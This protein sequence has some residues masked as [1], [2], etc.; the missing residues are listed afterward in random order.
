MVIDMK[1]IQLLLN[2]GD[3]FIF[4][5]HKRLIDDYYTS[6]RLFSNLITNLDK[7][8][9]SLTDIERVIEQFNDDKVKI[10]SLFWGL[11]IKDKNNYKP[12]NLSKD[13]EIY[14]IP[15]PN[16]NV[17]S[18]SITEQKQMSHIKYISIEAIKRLEFI[19]E[20]KDILV[21][22]INEE[23]FNMNQF[24]VI[25]EKFLI[26]KNE[27]EDSMDIRLFNKS[28]KDHNVT[29]RATGTTD[30]VFFDNYLEV[31]YTK[32]SKY[33]YEPF[34]YFLIEGK[35]QD[36][37]K[38]V[39]QFIKYDAI[40]GKKSIGNGRIRDII[41]KEFVNNKMFEVNGD[42]YTNLSVVIPKNETEIRNI[43]SYSIEIRN[44]YVYSPYC[45]GINKKVIYVIKE[46]SI[47]NNKIKGKIADVTLNVQENQL[48]HN[49]YRY[50]KALLLPLGGD[51]NDK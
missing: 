21:R 7:I 45:N 42:L 23:K 12:S 34:M 49:V 4:G 5:N 35:L 51:N 43:L 33:I 40:G 8:G 36:K 48:P 25:Q 29:N 14:F 6:D 30:D 24:L 9:Y 17:N 20:D 31:N 38:K 41:I 13:R 3:R 44:G 26:L 27:I 46:G 50:G 10:S 2:H 18:S 15:F 22:N 47:F 32:T 11:K 19:Q 16:V 28:I 1:C 39:I 37:I